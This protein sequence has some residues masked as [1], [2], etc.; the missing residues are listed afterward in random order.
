MIFF[1]FFLIV[2]ATCSV[3]QEAEAMQVPGHDFVTVETIVDDRPFFCQECIERERNCNDLPA[4]DTNEN[5]AVSGKDIT[6]ASG[7]RIKCIEPTD[8]FSTPRAV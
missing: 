3:S 7:F 6:I 1:R 5:A 4:M 2:V 8:P